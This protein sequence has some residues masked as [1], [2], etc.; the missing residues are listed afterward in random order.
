MTIRS[1]KLGWIL[2]L[3]GIYYF[4]FFLTELHAQTGNTIRLRYFAGD[5]IQTN[6][7]LYWANYQ[8]SWH[9]FGIG[10]SYVDINETVG[11]YSDRI[12]LKY[13]DFS[14]TFGQRLN[15][16]LGFGNLSQASE[17]SS[18]QSSTGYSW[19]AETIS[20]TPS[21]FAVIG[22]EVLGFM[23]LIIGTR[24]SQYKV[25]DFERST[26]S[27][28]NRITKFYDRSVGVIMTGLGIAF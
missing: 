4:G 10:S 7:N 13:N 23:E 15:L 18:Y 9:G 11:G 19:K 20:G 14:Y 12:L 17:A 22:I 1:L 26:S 16:T 21:Y 6:Q 27:G 8:L 28:T 25:R 3:L 2:P 24:A 5:R